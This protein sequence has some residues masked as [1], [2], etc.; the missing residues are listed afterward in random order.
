MSDPAH[1]IGGKTYENIVRKVD[2]VMGE[3]VVLMLV[4]VVVVVAHVLLGRSCVARLFRRIRW[5]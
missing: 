2:D 3:L 4:F 1:S 5:P